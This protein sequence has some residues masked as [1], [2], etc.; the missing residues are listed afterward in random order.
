MP[1]KPK[2]HYKKLPSLY[3]SLLIAFTLVLGSFM[4]LFSG[5]S[6]PIISSRIQANI[7]SLLDRSLI[8]AWHEYNRFFRETKANL[9]IIASLK[10]VTALF[11]GGDAGEVAGLLNNRPQ[12]DF[13]QAIDNQGRVIA[14]SGRS[15]GDPTAS[16][17]GLFRES[18][19]GGETLTSSEVVPI[20]TITYLNPGLKDRV[21]VEIKDLDGQSTNTFFNGALIQVVAVPVKVEGQIL[22]CLV[23]GHLLN[24]D[25]EIAGNYTHK[26][27]GSFLSI[28]VQ[29]VRIAANIQGASRM[30][31]VGL[32]QPPTLVTTIEAGKRYIGQAQ[33]SPGEIHLVVSDPIY[34]STGRIIGEFSVGVP[35]QG[36][37]NI[38]RDTFL[39]ILAALAICLLLGLILAAFLS[40]RITRP[41]T[42][43]SHLAKEI[44]QTESVTKEH[45]DRLEQ[46]NV[47]DI[48]EIWYLQRCF[49]RM[50]RSLYQ[51]CKETETYMQELENDRRQLQHL[52]DELTEANSLLE[53]RVEERTGE[54]KKAVIELKALNHLKTQFLANMSHELRTP[55]NSII[56]FSEMLADELFGKLNP[57]QKEY[58]EIVL[59]SSRHLLQVISDILDLARIEQGKI[60]LNKERVNLEELI[61]AVV[62]IIKPQAN[63]RE[64][65]LRVDI[66]PQ[67]PQLAIDPVRIK[68]VLY[69]LLS[70]AIKFTAPA[71]KI[72]LRAWYKKDE[73]A[74]SV[75]DTGI[76]IKPEDQQRVFDEFYQCESLYQ[77]K[78]EGVGLGLPL[79]KKLIELHQGRIELQ[80]KYG[81]GTEVIFYLPAGKLSQES[82]EGGQ[83]DGKPGSRSFAG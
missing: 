64:L 10:G 30:N 17:A 16:I 3:T 67:L 49:N 43:F 75:R 68:Q 77:R 23:A 76:G 12:V 4:A 36:I 45:I 11:S 72:T 71:G 81:Q 13:W 46:I 32:P 40:R 14:A 58:V 21:L 60:V 38:K 7:N 34:N 82:S 28:G 73:V 9:D 41:V 51:K 65:E 59:R 18:W 31:F 61:Q 26:V 20:N 63:G 53:K 80:S 25:Y 78:F 2:E 39:A 79:S 57:T 70:N 54:L 74:V 33:I 83:Q 15:E 66:Q 27:P 19:A 5:F 52:A 48:Q 1:R 47:P 22:G 69:N 8:I 55:L 50:A 62:T 24:N 35:S 44:S 56:G 6:L 29:G 42:T 37:T